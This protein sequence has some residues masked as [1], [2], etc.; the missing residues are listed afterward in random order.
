MEFKKAVELSNKNT[1]IIG[2]KHK[3]SI[4]DEIIVCPTDPDM[5]NHFFEN[6]LL[7]GNWE[8]AI[9]PY[10]EKDM[11]VVVIM[12]RHRIRAQ[13]LLVYKNIF[14]LPDELGAIID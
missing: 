4:I 14:N 9:A 6:Y 11:T 8:Q 12:D 13:S 7:F 3:D 2:K 1:H 5:F 10:I